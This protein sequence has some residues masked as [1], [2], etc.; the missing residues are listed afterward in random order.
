MQYKLL[1]DDEIIKDIGEKIEYLRRVKG[2]QSKELCE[3]G[4]AGYTAY[5]NLVNG[6]GGVSLRSFVE[7]LRGLG[8]LDRLEKL[9]DAGDSYAPT[10]NNTPP[11]KRIFKKTTPKK[12][13]WGDEL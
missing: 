4:G 1:G 2:I 5:R 8:E 10:G 9:L 7:L 12:K 13:I 3:R 11:P 6:K